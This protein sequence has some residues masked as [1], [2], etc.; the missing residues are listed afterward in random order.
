MNYMYEAFLRFRRNKRE[1][2]VNEL[3]KQRCI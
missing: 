3:S 2:A 1:H